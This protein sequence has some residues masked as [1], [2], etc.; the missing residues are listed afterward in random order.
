VLPRHFLASTG[1]TDEIEA[2]ALPFEVA[3]VHVDMVWHTRNQN[4]SAQQ[5]LRE[6]LARAGQAS[7]GQKSSVLV[8]AVT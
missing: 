7:F 2:I 3:P 4:D 6:A 8:F 5:W 1:I